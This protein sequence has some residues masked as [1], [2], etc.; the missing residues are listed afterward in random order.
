MFRQIYSSVKYLLDFEETN[1]FG[2]SLAK[3]IKYATH[4]YKQS[5]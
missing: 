5:F 1:I 3:K 4:C 2:Y